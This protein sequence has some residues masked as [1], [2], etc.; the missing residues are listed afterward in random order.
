MSP[1]STIASFADE[2]V[3]FICITGLIMAM[4][5]VLL[6]ATSFII[7]MGW[8]KSMNT[9]QKG[10]DAAKKKGASSAEPNNNSIL[11]KQRA[12]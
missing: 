10:D 1:Y 8:T 7:L 9:G 3:N 2:L 4:S 6:W 5:V 12:S 11:R